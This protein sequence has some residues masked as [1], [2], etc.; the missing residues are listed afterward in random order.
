MAVLRELRRRARHIAPPVLAACVLSY[1]AYHA[2]QGDRG[3]LA[4]LQ[5]R[6][7]LA[8]AQ[9]EDARLTSER[10]RL[11]Q[12]VSLLRAESLDPDL[13][14]ERAHALLGYGRPDEYV[15]LRPDRARRGPE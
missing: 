1:F 15:L 2:I 13:L 7:D 3:L 11:E 5:L 12:R 6:Q 8:E 10:A 9:A 4:W 14:D